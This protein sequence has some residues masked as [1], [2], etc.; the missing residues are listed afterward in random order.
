MFNDAVDFRK[1]NKNAT[2]ERSIISKSKVMTLRV[3]GAI[4]LMRESL[5]LY[6]RRQVSIV[7]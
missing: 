5:E 1:N 6:L 4:A 2:N 7:Y 3:A